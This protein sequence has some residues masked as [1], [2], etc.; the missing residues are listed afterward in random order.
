[1]ERHA[2]TRCSDADRDEVVAELRRHAVAGRLEPAELDARLGH[3]LQSRTQRELRATL[4]NLPPAT[5]ATTWNERL[6]TMS[7]STATAASTAALA[8][9][10]WSTGHLGEDG[11]MWTVAA[12]ILLLVWRRPRPPRDT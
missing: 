4:D 1:M 9:M 2:D 11:M 3:A 7:R 8:I 5:R 10:L 12:A 6:A